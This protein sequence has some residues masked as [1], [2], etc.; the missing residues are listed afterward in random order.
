[1]DH[2]YHVEPGGKRPLW[3]DK[4]SP[5]RFKQIGF[6]MLLIALG[7]ALFSLRN[8]LGIAN[9]NNLAGAAGGAAEVTATPELSTS[10]PFPSPTATT[11]PTITLTPTPALGIGSSQIRASDGMTM[12]YVPAG[13]FT[14]GLAA[15]AALAEC[16]ITRGACEA[17]WFAD[18]NPPHRVEL[19][20]FWMDQ[21][22][23]TNA[24][25]SLCVGAGVCPPPRM[26]E[27]YTVEDYYEN[28]AYA[29]YPVVFIP[30]KQANAYCEW[31]GARLPSEAE[32]EKAARGPD[33]RL[34]PWGAARP[35]CALANI[36][37]FND[38]ACVEDVSAVRSYPNG[39][40]P[41][42]IFDM[43]GN[44]AEWVNDWY[45]PAYYA[46]SPAS[47]PQGPAE[48][49]AKILRGGSWYTDEDYANA[50]Y[51]YKQDPR[52]YYGFTGFRCAVSE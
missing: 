8:S 30:W 13:P 33:G 47:D 15:E 40:S 29:N 18:I 19:S 1:M 24:M 23:V 6:L 10:T 26:K 20:A 9:A 41:Y 39:Q 2:Q 21:T 4:K 3:T 22:E 51:R 46:D 42:Q 43:V 28:P 36:N 32:W 17:I 49:M 35:E 27:S 11:P 16:V 12:M 7:I 48:G 38:S 25:Y 5:S 45:S 52:Y 31:A 37:P 50:A 44:A 34:Y 14:M